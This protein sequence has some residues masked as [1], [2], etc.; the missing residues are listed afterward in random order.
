MLELDCEAAF[1]RPAFLPVPARN[2]WTGLPASAL[3]CSRLLANA[4]LAKREKKA[5]LVH[6]LEKLPDFSMQARA[7]QRL[8]SPCALSQSASRLCQTAGLQRL[9][10]PAHCFDFCSSTGS[11]VLRCLARSCAATPQTTRI[12]SPRWADVR[13]GGPALGLLCGDAALSGGAMQVGKLLRVDGTLM[14]LDNRSRSLIPRWKRGHFSL[15]VDAGKK[16]GLGT[17]HV[18]H[19]APSLPQPLWPPPSRCPEDASPTAAFLVDHQQR[20]FYDLYQERKAHRKPIDEEVG[21]RAS[22][23]RSPCCRCTGDASRCT[24]SA[25]CEFRWLTCWPRARARCGWPRQS[26]ISNP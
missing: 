18:G 6:V 2:L 16:V 9:T 8:G 10:M 14:G 7:R 11:L 4:K 19:V 13:G 21:G 5:Q 26:L 17:K 3:P 12:S 23:T 25:W 22:Q 24:A 1:A 15:L 20:T